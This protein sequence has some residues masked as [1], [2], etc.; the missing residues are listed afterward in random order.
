V[1]PEEIVA[2]VEQEVRDYQYRPAPGARGRSWTPDRVRAELAALERAL[3]PPKRAKF[4]VRDGAEQLTDPEPEIALYW[5]VARDM[6]GTVVFYDEAD[7]EFGL[8][9]VTP[10]GHLA[11][12][13]VRG[14]LVGVFM[15]R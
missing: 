3:N 13:G 7:D 12:V 1:E 6:E 9:E 8:G 11:T 5:L 14:D 2:R 4:E 15:A 10:E